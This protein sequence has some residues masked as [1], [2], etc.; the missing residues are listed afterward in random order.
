MVAMGDRELGFDGQWKVFPEVGHALRLV[1]E[2]ML[3][4]A[5]AFP[6]WL[7]TAKT[8]LIPKKGKANDPGNYRPIAC[9]NTQC[10][11][12]TAVLADS[13][14]AHV[15][16]ND[17]L[18]QEQRA[19]R[20]GPRGCVDCLVVDKMVITNAHFKR[21]RTLNM[22]WINFEKAYNRVPH[23]WVTLVLSK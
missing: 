3:N 8:I 5:I 11:F 13:L 14:A 19:L 2:E 10:K 7:V 12:A 17:L 4:A 20:K 18:P 16:A 22:G 1:T 15:E 9:L 21:L 23:E 6:D